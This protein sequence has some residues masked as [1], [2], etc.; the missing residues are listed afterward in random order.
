MHSVFKSKH[1]SSE[2]IEELASICMARFWTV[3]MFIEKERM[4]M[5][6]HASK[7]SLVKF[8]DEKMQELSFSIE[9]GSQLQNKN[10]GKHVLAV[11]EKSADPGVEGYTRE[12]GVHH[13]IDMTLFLR[14]LGNQTVQLTVMSNGM[15]ITSWILKT[16]RDGV[17][18]IQVIPGRSDLNTINMDVDLNYFEFGGGR[19]LNIIDSIRIFGKMLASNRGIRKQPNMMRLLMA[20]GLELVVGYLKTSDR[21][22]NN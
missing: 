13:I 22:E 12:V 5:I 14:L 20:G 4:H 8:I 6:R 15:A 7:R 16:T 3:D 11:I 1:I 9:I 19:S 10:L 2:R 21:T 17:E 18:Y